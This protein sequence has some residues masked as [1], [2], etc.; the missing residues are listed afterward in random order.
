M[1]LI[2]DIGKAIK[3]FPQ[4]SINYFLFCLS[5]VLLFV[6]GGIAPAYWNHMDLI[7]KIKDEKRMIEESGMLQPLSGSLQ[8]VYGSAPPSLMVPPR[9]ALKRS[10]IERIDTLFRDMADQSGMKVVSIMPD[11]VSGGDSHVLLVDV[12]LKGDFDHFR[13]VLKKLGEL[14]YVDHIEEFAIQRSGNARALDITM[15]ISLAVS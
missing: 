6:F 11:L 1:K 9:V 2:E 14:P 10:E 8:D 7:Q 4:R 3:K 13:T 12:S 15:Q 5:G